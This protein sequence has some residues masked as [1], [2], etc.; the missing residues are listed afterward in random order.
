MNLDKQMEKKL[1]YAPPPVLIPVDL[2]TTEGTSSLTADSKIQVGPGPI[3]RPDPDGDIEPAAPEPVSETVVSSG[4]MLS[5]DVVTPDATSN[6]ISIGDGV[7]TIRIFSLAPAA[8]EVSPP[9]PENNNKE[10]YYHIPD[11]MEKDPEI[12]RAEL[13]FYYTPESEQYSER[14]YQSLVHVEEQCSIDYKRFC[15][16]F[17]PTENDFVDL[18]DLVQPSLLFFNAAPMFRRNLMG[19]ESFSGLEW[20]NYFRSF[21]SPTITAK[22]TNDIVSANTANAFGL[23]VNKP[24]V[25]ST[26]L[27]NGK[28]QGEAIKAKELKLAQEIKEKQQH[29]RVRRL[30]G[31][32]EHARP[33]MRLEVAHSYDA[34]TPSLPVER[35]PPGAVPPAGPGIPDGP[36]LVPHHLLLPSV[37]DKM[38]RPLSPIGHLEDV[39]ERSIEAPSGFSP[40]VI[41]PPPDVGRPVPPRM[42]YDG[43]DGS[44]K[45]SPPG[46][47]QPPRRQHPPRPPSNDDDSDD[48]DQPRGSAGRGHWSGSD[49][50]TDGDDDEEPVYRS[51]GGRRGRLGNP[52]PNPWEDH[53][54]AGALGFG[55]RGDMCMYN[56]FDSLSSS[57]KAAISDVHQLREEY[58]SNHVSSTV[59]YHHHSIIMPILALVGLVTLVKRCCMHKRH[60]AVKEFLKGIHADP[61]LKKT[62]EARLGKVVPES[63]QCVHE[64]QGLCKRVLTFVAFFIFALLASFVITITSLELTSFIVTKMD[65]NASSEDELVG[66]NTAMFILFA[67]CTAQV[68][69]LSGLIYKLKQKWLQ[70]RNNQMTPSAPSLT[71]ATA[72]HNNISGS[73]D[74][75]SRPGGNGLRYV[76]V[77]IRNWIS[78]RWQSLRSAMT[79]FSIS[80]QN[81]DGYASLNGEDESTEMIAVTGGMNSS[82]HNPQRYTIYTGT[83]LAAQATH[84]GMPVGVAVAPVTAVP[85]TTVNFV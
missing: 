73:S 21:Y 22:L 43:R 4:P 83:P 14:V 32:R 16:A 78:P 59:H 19:T 42:K 1:E 70:R 28:L 52:P 34:S 64:Q 47:P 35:A 65:E 5:N 66:P 67:I 2:A 24:T 12:I 29:N 60:K 7:A 57:C 85:V 56:N 72:Y 44:G 11:G 45:E 55:A 75:N 23:K 49:S 79:S 84:L 3:L 48:G 15:N 62:V 17:G 38:F 26:I 74:G 10:P 71:A 39:G 50:D 46:K 8:R 36:P 54:F 68:A 53:S 80:R 77:R 41:G 69:L 63:V 25:R 18:N 6:T 31:I 61:E 33:P 82:V 40:P 30:D 20:V 76:P 9:Y 37:F 51:R 81:P 13:L 58:W 27:I